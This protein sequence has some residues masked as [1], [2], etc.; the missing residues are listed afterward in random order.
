MDVGEVQNIG[1]KLQTVD[2]AAADLK[3]AEA[4]AEERRAMAVA[5]E[6]EMIAKGTG[7]RANVIQAEARSPKP[8]PRLL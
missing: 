2:Q 8:L 3:V 6:Q 4:R 1:A 5:M 7:A